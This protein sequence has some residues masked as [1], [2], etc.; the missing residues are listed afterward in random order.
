[1]SRGLVQTYIYAAQAFMNMCESLQSLSS[2]SNDIKTD[3]QYQDLVNQVEMIV[4]Q[5]P[6]PTYFLKPTV[7]TLIELIGAKFVLHTDAPAPGKGGDFIAK[8][9]AVV[10][11]AAM[12]RAVGD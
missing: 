9:E 5:A 2:S 6:W 1:G 7:A 10:T 4:H 3:Q 8:L 12:T 11:P